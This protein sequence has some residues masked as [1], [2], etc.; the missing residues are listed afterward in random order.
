MAQVSLS[1]S[2][3]GLRPTPSK[4]AGGTRFTIG[5]AGNFEDR[6]MGCLLAM[7]GRATRVTGV[8]SKCLS[9]QAEPII[10]VIVFTSGAYIQAVRISSLQMARF[11]F[12]RIQPNRLLW[13][14]GVGTEG[15]WLNYPNK[16]FSRPPR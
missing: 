3:N 16:R 2:V 5:I 1:L 11:T 7:E 4:P 10:A 12:F 13:R 15:K 6:T 9:D 14:W 8:L